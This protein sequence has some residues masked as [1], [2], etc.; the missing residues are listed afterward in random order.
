LSRARIGLLTSQG[1]PLLGYVVDRISAILDTD[2]LVICDSKDV[3]ERDQRLF[4]EQTEGALEPRPFERGTYRWTTVTDHN[5]PDTLQLI[6]REHIDLLVNVCTP[7]RITPRL[8]AEPRLG[9]LNVHPGILPRYRGASCCEWA[10]YNDDPVGVSAHFMDDGLDS[11][12]IIFTRELEVTPGQIY[13]QAR[14]ELY[15]L[16]VDACGEA[17]VEVLGQGLTP[18]VLPAQ[19]EF[20]VFKPIPDGLL[21]EVKERLARGTYTG[22][23]REGRMSV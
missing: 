16:W 9:V 22:A 3:T 4:Q 21:A 15:K 18:A 6:R 8:L 19:P 12:P 5:G 20:P 14:V 23:C 17:V 10:I 11:G 2:L 13:T 1:Y 7:R